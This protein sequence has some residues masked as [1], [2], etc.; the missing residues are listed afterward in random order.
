MGPHTPSPP[1][2]EQRTFEQLR[3]EQRGPR[4][5]RPRAIVRQIAHADARDHAN[6]LADGRVDP[7]QDAALRELK[8]LFRA[9][10]AGIGVGGQFQSVWFTRW[11]DETGQRPR[12]IDARAIGGI[13]GPC[14]SR[15]WIRTIGHQPD[16]GN[17]HT[18]HQSATRP[19]F[20]IVRLPPEPSAPDLMP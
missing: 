13:V 6:D 19:L 7:A 18:Q 14:L 5:A 20:R 2:P 1:P 15:G 8:R 4:A 11:L 12:G 10:L 17:P 16:G 9:Y 3:A